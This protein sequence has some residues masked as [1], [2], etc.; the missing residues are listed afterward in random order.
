[1]KVLGLITARGGSKR[2]PRKN[3]KDFLGKPLLYWTIKTAQKSGVF[4]RLILTTDDKE[5]AK[6]GK[7]Y[8]VKIP[9]LRPKEL[10]TDTAS[11]LSV[12]QHAVNWLKEKENYCADWLILLEPSSPGRQPWHIRE[13]VDLIEKRKDFDSIVGISELS[14][15]YSPLKVLQVDNK[16]FVSRYPDGEKIKN[17]IHRNQDLPKLYFINSAIY[18]FRTK[19]IS[20][21]NPC[22]WGEKT[23]GY[24]MNQKY[25]LDIDT[26]DDWILAEFKMKQILREKKK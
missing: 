10:A 13:V 5:I 6:I 25:S 4:D 21:K 22:L 1:M 7:K 18:A 17:L 12:V 2:I 26:Q 23:L 8:G 19:N 11:S 24:V 20:S 9:F 14:G 16:K 3:I 15:H